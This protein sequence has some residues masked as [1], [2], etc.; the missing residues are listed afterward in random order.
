M[1]TVH[2]TSRSLA[3]APTAERLVWSVGLASAVTLSLAA[4]SSATDPVVASAAAFARATDE[5]VDGVAAA[6]P[7]FLA[8]LDPAAVGLDPAAGQPLFADDRGSRPAP[9]VPEMQADRDPTA[10]DVLLRDAE[11]LELQQRDFDAALDG[12]RR[13]IE[14]APDTERRATARLRAI[15]LAVHARRLDDARELWL[16]MRAA[17]DRLARH[18]D[19]SALLMA[20]LS[21]AGTDDPELLAQ[22]GTEVAALLERDQL[23]LPAADP[24]IARDDHGRLVITLSPRLTILVDRIRNELGLRDDPHLDAGLRRQRS[25]AS[26]AWL[27]IA[28]GAALATIPSLHFRDDDALLIHGDVR[29]PQGTWLTRAEVLRAFRQS[30][31]ERG[32]AQGGFAVDLRGDDASL[33]PPVADATPLCGDALS[34]T[35]RHR[36]P[37]GWRAHHGERTGLLRAALL[38]AAAFSA[39]AGLI[40]ARSL[41]RQRQLALLRA[42][43]IANASHELRTPLSSILLMA[44]NLER[45]VVTSREGQH[46]YHGVI[47]QE[48]ARLRRLVDD[49]L[50]FS[51]LER[52][53]G[54]RIDPE[55]C[56]LTAFVE[57]LRREVAERVA[58]MDGTLT[59][60]TNALPDHAWLD[61]A[62]ILRAVLNL[63][64]NALI[65]GGGEVAVHI[66]VTDTLRIAVTDRGTGVPHAMRE[67]IF[68]PF[69]QLPGAD[70]ETHGTG[71]G[72]AI[73]REIAQHHGGRA[74]VGDRADGPGASFLLE[75]PQVAAS[76]R[77]TQQSPEVNP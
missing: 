19:V 73:V 12:L 25:T 17:Q 35:L 44:E 33:G 7:R 64:D 55:A 22:A 74:A 45:G 65:H 14:L 2:T 67:R 50:D 8:R 40:T 30:L 38:I 54:L 28:P 72:L 1:S 77:T 75:I 42:R 49:V 21:L 23:V 41:R 52:G 57:R 6:W 10:F 76:D 9:I 69:V 26:F 60:T 39:V 68:E 63:V 18:G 27:G 53:Q 70:G 15:Q 3:A 61:Q 71:L 46:R 5:V 51:R 58:A 62:A 4:F 43:F 37:D 48:A 29:N 32:L 56:A 20:A 66:D 13:A 11:L 16:A 59:F 34:F 24:T 31:T 47:R 36:D